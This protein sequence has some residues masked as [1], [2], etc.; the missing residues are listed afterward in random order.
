MAKCIGNIYKYHTWVRRADTDIELEV[1]LSLVSNF[2]EVD[3]ALEL[4]VWR[5]W[6]RFVSDVCFTDGSSLFKEVSDS[7][8]SNLV[9]H[10]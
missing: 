10:G 3:V 2:E 6:R 9:I 7:E 8:N 4:I 5:G 1:Y